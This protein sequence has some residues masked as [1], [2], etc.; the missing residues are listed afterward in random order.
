MYSNLTHVNT[1]TKKINLNK[2]TEAK[3]FVDKAVQVNT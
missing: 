1:S 2:E 3:Q